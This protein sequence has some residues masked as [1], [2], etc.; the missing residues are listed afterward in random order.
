MKKSLIFFHLT[1]L[2][3]LK[4][5]LVHSQ[6]N[7][8]KILNPSP[9]NSH[10]MDLFINDSKDTLV[11]FNDPMVTINSKTTYV[12]PFKEYDH[13][14][15]A[16]F[17]NDKTGFILGS[18]GLLLKTVDGGKTWET[19]LKKGI[20]NYFGSFF[21]VNDSISYMFGSKGVSNGTDFSFVSYVW[22]SSDK[23]KTWKVYLAPINNDPQS[24]YLINPHKVNDS[25]LIYR[26]Q[27]YLFITDNDF[28]IRTKKFIDYGNQIYFSSID[29]GF[30]ERLNDTGFSTI[31]RT[32]DGGKNYTSSY[33]TKVEEKIRLISFFN[34]DT[35]VAFTSNN[36]L[37][38][39]YDYGNSWNIKSNNIEKVTKIKKIGNSIFVI[40]EEGRIYELSNKLK[41]LTEISNNR[42]KTIFLKVSFNEKGFGVI[43]N[44]GW[45]AT[46]P[47]LISTSN[48]GRTLQKR[49]ITNPNIG[50]FNSFEIAG[51]NVFYIDNMGHLF[52]SDTLFTKWEE[53]GYFSQIELN[54]IRKSNDSLLYCFDKNNSIYLSKDQGINWNKIYSIE[55]EPNGNNYFTNIYTN[56]SGKQLLIHYTG[57]LYE[58]NPA[59]GSINLIFTNDNYFSSNAFTIMKNEVYINSYE[60]AIF[61]NLKTKSI[62]TV[63]VSSIING[64]Q[65]IFVDSLKAVGIGFT[66][67]VSSNDGGITWEYEPFYQRSQPNSIFKLPYTNAIFVVGS[68]GL[69]AMKGDFPTIVTEDT[70]EIKPNN[71]DYIINYPNPIINATTVLFYSNKDDEYDFYIFDIMGKM[72]IKKE[73]QLTHK[74]ENK[75]KINLSNLSSGLYFLEIRKQ[76]KSLYHKVLKIH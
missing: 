50:N 4:V 8:W 13:F 3:I 49:I 20:G 44:N 32:I 1:I 16:G 21:N 17:I 52:K 55:N 75:F 5:N 34:K 70:T 31:Y 46:Q 22:K 76:N 42:F 57:K 12:Q 61:Y 18:N 65:P 56:N 9:Q 14:S 37:L 39:S 24:K 69:I 40:C 64:S 71:S 23:G 66:S 28:K 51:K 10:I 27:Y 68:D 33:N 47:Y 59:D 67:L 30:I 74:G 26:S 58:G 54:E 29:S 25:T 45:N 2:L 35:L 19:I 36:N 7:K 11:F 53:I 62:R 41:T 63:K 73:S 38:I 43:I 48:F 15:S 6:E 60:K 72:L